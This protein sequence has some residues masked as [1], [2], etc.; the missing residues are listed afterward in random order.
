MDY[1]L[2]DA[3]EDDLRAIIR[4]TR[5]Q[6]GD[7]QV[8]RYITELEQGIVRLAVGKG[9]FKDMSEIF[10]ALRM[11]RCEHHYVFCLPRKNAPALIVAIF[12]ERMNLLTRLADRLI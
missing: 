10:P 6:W 7:K 3:A 5:Q 11:A 12:H 1:V 9:S 4:Y 2:T 8:H